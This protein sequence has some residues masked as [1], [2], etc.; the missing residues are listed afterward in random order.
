MAPP[1]QESGE[2]VDKFLAELAVGLSADQINVGAP[3]RSER[4]LINNLIKIETMMFNG[5]P[6]DVE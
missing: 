3:S 6:I 4:S 1:S 2:T 5:S